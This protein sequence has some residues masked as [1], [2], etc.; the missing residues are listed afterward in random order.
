MYN[1]V[2]FKTKEEAQEYQKTNGGQIYT[3]ENDSL[4]ADDYCTV[5]IMHGKTAKFM[6]EN[7]YVVSWL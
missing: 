3:C 6:S 4:T 1:A 7:P 2:F 5:A